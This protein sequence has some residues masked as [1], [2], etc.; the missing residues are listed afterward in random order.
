MLARVQRARFSD[1]PAVVRDCDRVLEQPVGGRWGPGR[2]SPGWWRAVWRTWLRTGFWRRSAA[3]SRAWS[4]GS[5]RPLAPGRSWIG[6]RRAV[7]VPIRFSLALR[8]GIS[9]RAIGT[10]PRCSMWSWSVPTPS[11]TSSWIAIF[12]SAGLV[13]G[14]DAGELPQPAERLGGRGHGHL[15]SL[16]PLPSGCRRVRAVSRLT[17]PAHFQSR[18]ASRAASGCGRRGRMLAQPVP[19]NFSLNFMKPLRYCGRRGGSESGRA[20]PAG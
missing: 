7:S 16:S 1:L 5:R 8:G 6:W 14:G 17:A 4:S 2:S 19:H 10:T 12:G 3:A 15:Q 18:L 20:Q 9:S 11:S 13:T